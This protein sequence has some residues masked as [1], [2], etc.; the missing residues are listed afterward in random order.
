MSVQTQSSSLGRTLYQMTWPMIFGVFSLMSYQ[1]VDAA[2]IGQLGVDPLAAFGFTLPMQQLIIGFQVG[3]GIATT[4]L[5][6]RARGAGERERAQR[7]GGL[8]VLSGAG[9]ILLLALLIWRL[10]V[11]LVSAMGAGDAVLPQIARYW[12]PWLLSAWIGAML[13]FGYSVCRSH[14]DTRLPGLMMVVTS[15]INLLLDPI[16]IFVFEWGLPG[17]AWATSASF[18]IGALVVY[19]RLW[20]RGWLAFDLAPQPA[21]AAMRQLSGIAGPAMISQLMPALSALLATT[22]VARFGDEA[23]AAWGVGA[24]LEFFSIVAVLALTMSLPP[25]VGR[26]MGEGRREQV[27][28][29]VW[30][31]VRFVL[32]WQLAVALLWLFGSGLLSGLLTGDAL[33]ADTLQ[34]YL[35]RVPLSYGPLGVCM[36]MVSVCNALGL[37]MRALGIAVSRLFVCY[38][39]A[40]WLGARLAGLDGLFTGALLGNVA[41]GAL[42]WLLYRRALRVLEPPQPGPTSA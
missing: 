36:I 27:Q 3:I 31:A 33:V 38:L 6:S 5:I 1:L 16:F 19:R 7:L 28:E 26:L 14:E 23:V 2:Y 17:A 13:Y 12:G 24:R 35:W 34:A 21:L 20:A 42:A 25:L 10:Q 39:P 4:A 22:L 41:A 29:L 30:L 18:G 11:P 40:L 8:V 15:L 37:P 32:L 9:L